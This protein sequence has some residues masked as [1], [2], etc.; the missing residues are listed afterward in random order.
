[1]AVSIE[2]GA[3]WPRPAAYCPV[4]G[5]A[6]VAAKRAGQWRPCCIKC[7]HVTYF[8]PKVATILWLQ[9]QHATLGERVLLVQRAIDPGAGRWALP[10][11]FVD[12]GEGAATAAIREAREELTVDVELLGLLAIFGREDNPEGDEGMADITIVYRARIVAGE[13]RAQDDAADCAWFTREKLPPLVFHP[14]RTLIAR[15][16]R[17][18][19]SA[20]S[21]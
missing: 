10:G 1:M 5:A 7:G 4:C 11:G 13:L 18:E 14:T 20:V 9:Q 6:T 2:V 3:R 16:R 15:W 17:G 8:D 21:G 12:A 19:P